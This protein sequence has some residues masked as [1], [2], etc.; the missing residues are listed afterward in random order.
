MTNEETA[1]FKRFHE[2]HAKAAYGKHGAVE[3]EEEQHIA[4][5]VCNLYAELNGISYPAAVLEL[6][7]GAADD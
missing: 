4:V 5:A 2:K 3:N 1:I 6:M 7:R